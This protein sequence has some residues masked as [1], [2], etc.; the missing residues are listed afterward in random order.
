[1]REIYGIIR[2]LGVTSNYKGYFFLADA[3]RLAMNSQGA[4]S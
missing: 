4:P 3:I 2:K 1:M